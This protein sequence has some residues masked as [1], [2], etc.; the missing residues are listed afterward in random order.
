[1]ERALQCCLE[2]VR[3]VPQLADADYVERSLEMLRNRLCCLRLP[4]AWRAEEIDDKATSGLLLG[5]DLG[6]V[7]LYEASKWVPPI[8]WQDETCQSIIG[9]LDRTDLGD[10]KF[11]WGCTTC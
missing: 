1:M 9:P 8:I 3:V 4:N 5:Y 10:T 2:R 11:H 6:V 7:S